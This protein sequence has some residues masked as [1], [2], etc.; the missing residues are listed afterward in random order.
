MIPR[1]GGRSFKLGKHFFYIFGDTFCFDDKRNF[2]G[3]TNNTLAW[4]PNRQEPIK[5]SYLCSDP[6]VPPGIPLT[7]EE[8]AFD[9]EHKKENWRVMTWCFGGVVEDEPKECGKGWMWFEKVEGVRLKLHPCIKVPIFGS[10]TNTI[11]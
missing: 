2:V 7:P 10:S 6:R 1:D 9:K 8:E 11:L 4:I 3:V 5:S